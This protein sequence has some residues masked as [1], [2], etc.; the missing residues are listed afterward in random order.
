MGNYN[1]VF[2]E[3]VI[4]EI[5]VEAENLEAAKKMVRTGEFDASEAYEV[6]T[7]NP[8]IIDAEEL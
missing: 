1:I 6:E 7:E 5:E 3:V 2:K 8:V 4:K